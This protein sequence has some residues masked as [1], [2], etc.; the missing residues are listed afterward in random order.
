MNFIPLYG[1]P[2]KVNR[3]NK[4]RAVTGSVASEGVGANLFV[5]NLDLDVDDKV[6]CHSF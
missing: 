4:D 6:C 2:I 1:K 5:G 3:S